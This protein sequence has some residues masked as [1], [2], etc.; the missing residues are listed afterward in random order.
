MTL[1]LA[2]SLLPFFLFVGGAFLIY[3]ICNFGRLSN[4]VEAILTSI[5]LLLA[6]FA[7]FVQGSILMGAAIT[8]PWNQVSLIVPEFNLSA[9]LIGIFVVSAACIVGIFICIYSG[10]YLSRDPRSLLYYPLILL[11][12]AGL[13]GMFY[14]GDLFS[15]FILA[16]VTT[17]TASGLTAF[18]FDQAAAVRAGYQYLVMSSLGTL[19]MMLGIYFIYRET[20]LLDIAALADIQNSAITIGGACFGLGFCIKAGVAPVHA[21][22]PKV[23]A[24]APSAISGLFASVT[25]KAMLFILPGVVL[26]LNITPEQI[27]IF[28]VAFS[29]ASM[30]VGVI[31]MLTQ[32]NLR[33]LLAFSAITHT[34]Y[35]MFILGIYFLYGSPEALVAA[36]FT[37]LSIAMM[38]AMGFLCVGVYEYIL[39]V[40]TI[41]SIKG[42]FQRMPFTAISFSIALAGLAGIP[43]FAG[44]IGK[45]LIYSAAVSTRAPLVLAGFA[46][47]LLC[48]ILALVSYLSVLI[49]QFQPAEEQMLEVL[50]PLSL[51]MKL[52]VGVLGFSVVLLGIL[53]SPVL[54]VVLRLAGR[55]YF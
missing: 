19:V 17:I 41:Q 39:Q 35:L 1:D 8:R 32:Q 42:A 24:N 37:F 54:D 4:K 6:I 46:V 44:F 25:S 48:S 49:R 18:R 43:L 10:E 38:K 14:V 40:K 31:R 5:I 30:L 27:G 20:A 34:G 51:W 9:S 12:F 26:K 21:W 50:S 33:R 7:L 45:W 3:L 11:L 22:V 29:I 13:L 2:L 15:L 23:Y 16:E 52:P 53:P 36:L 47:F 55:M 28:L